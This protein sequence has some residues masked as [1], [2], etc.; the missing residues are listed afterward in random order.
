M[1]LLCVSFCPVDRMS[2]LGIGAC[3][4]YIF[5]F[6]VIFFYH[7]SPLAVLY[8]LTWKYA[9]KVNTVSRINPRSFKK[10]RRRI[11]N[12]NKKT[13]RAY[14]Q[15]GEILVVGCDGGSGVAS[16]SDGRDA[17]HSPS[18]VSAR[19]SHRKHLMSSLDH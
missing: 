9:I 10:Q 6:V 13:V 5:V 19:F 16:A 17:A 2:L 1:P 3:I 14:R 18:S 7:S 8:S 12:R 15:F 4:A 11:S